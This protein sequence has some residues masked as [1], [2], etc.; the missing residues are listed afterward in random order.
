MQKKEKDLNCRRV[1]GNLVTCAVVAAM[2]A[3]GCGGAVQEEGPAV[4]LREPELPRI[5]NRA[6]VEAPEA[7]TREM[8]GCV[9]AMNH[10]SVGSSHAFQYNLGANEQ[11]TVLKVKLHDSTLRDTS[12]EACFERALSAMSVPKDALWSRSSKPFSGSES[13]YSSRA[14][15]GIVQAAAAPIALVPIFITALGVTIIVAIT[16]D[17]IRTATSGPNCK[18]VKAECIIYCSDTTLPTPDFGWK[19]QKC[20]NECLESQGCPRDS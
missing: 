5:A 12:L 18:Q 14:E 15:V 9:E 19:F 16:I 20:K 8:K 10:P 1:T 11:G 2:P 17:I 7:T 13:T 4:V 6:G 3:F